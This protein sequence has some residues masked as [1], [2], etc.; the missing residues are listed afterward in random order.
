MCPRALIPGLR[1]RT[2][3]R[4]CPSPYHEFGRGLRGVVVK[5]LAA[6]A[7]RIYRRLF[8]GSRCFILAVTSF[9]RQLNADSTAVSRRPTAGRQLV[10]GAG[11][12]PGTGFCFVETSR[13]LSMVVGPRRCPHPLLQKLTAGRKG[14]RS[15]R[16]GSHRHPRLDSEQAKYSSRRASRVI[17]EFFH[18]ED[19]RRLT[20]RRVDHLHRRGWAEIT[21]RFAAN[22]AHWHRA[23]EMPRQRS[24]GTVSQQET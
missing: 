3:T 20:P 22:A 17:S 8:R 10:Y 4:R 1:E 9:A 6:G 19:R 23:N 11:C 21:C 14:N 15:I 7:L 24:H 13:K 18:A 16:M 12:F 2:H 5:V